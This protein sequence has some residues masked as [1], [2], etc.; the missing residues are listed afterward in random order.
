MSLRRHLAH[1][2]SPHQ[3]DSQYAGMNLTAAE[4]LALK[5]VFFTK[6]ESAAVIVNGEEQMSEGYMCASL[7][8]ARS[9]SFSLLSL[10]VLEGP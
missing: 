2:Y 5:D 10:Q 4:S 1:A 8:L 9:S 3:V 6:L 7:N